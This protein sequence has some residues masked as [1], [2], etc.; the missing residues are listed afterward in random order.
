MTPRALGYEA[1]TR[2]RDGDIGATT[3]AA[4][5]YPPGSCSGGLND[6]A[7]YRA[8]Y[9]LGMDART[10]TGGPSYAERLGL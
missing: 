10:V 2:H 5:L 3:R 1:G 4:E 9:R 7:E 8:G 6:R